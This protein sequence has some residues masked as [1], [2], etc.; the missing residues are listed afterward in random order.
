MSPSKPFIPTMLF[1]LADHRMGLLSKE[2]VLLALSIHFLETS[3]STAGRVCVCAVTKQS[4]H[5]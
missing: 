2:Y 4:I 5:S 1:L 3:A